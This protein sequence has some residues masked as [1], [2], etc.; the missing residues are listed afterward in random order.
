MKVIVQ[1]QCNLFPKQFVICI[2]L[3]SKQQ[4]MKENIANDI[5]V[6]YTDITE[7]NADLADH[8]YL[9]HMSLIGIKLYCLQM[10]LSFKT[11]MRYLWHT[12]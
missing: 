4:A 1:K 8:P 9:L 5:E 7:W 2:F 11:V 6:L 10:H 12:K 3:L